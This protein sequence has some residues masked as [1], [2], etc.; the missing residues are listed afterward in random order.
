MRAWVW[1]VLSQT[2]LVSADSRE[3]GSKTTGVNG[4]SVYFDSSSGEFRRSLAAPRTRMVGS[5]EIIKRTPIRTFPTGG[6]VNK[7]LK[8]R[9]KYR[10]GP[11]RQKKLSEEE[12]KPPGKEQA[13][14][15]LA[16][17]KTKYK[18]SDS[19]RM[20]RRRPEDVKLS[21]NN[22]LPGRQQQNKVGGKMKKQNRINQIRAEPVK[23]LQLSEKFKFKQKPR[24]PSLL[25]AESRE[26]R[27]YNYFHLEEQPDQ[28]EEVLLTSGYHHQLSIQDP[29]YDYTI[30]GKYFIAALAK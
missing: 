17:L 14:K 18:T 10:R 19:I 5:A 8:R 11:V 28:P 1:L 29:A 27:N 25:R 20:H 22:D 21:S 3:R 23:P 9:K 6:T 15:K 30:G 12:T 16:P 2:L 26:D 7:V 24:P 4:G 13:F